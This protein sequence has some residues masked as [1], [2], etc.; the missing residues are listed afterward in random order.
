MEMWA[1]ISDLHMMDGT[2]HAEPSAIQGAVKL[3]RQVRELAFEKGI[4]DF[5]LVLLGDTIDLLRSNRWH[6]YKM[7]PD[8][9]PGRI[10]AA[11]FARKT[12]EKKIEFINPIMNGVVANPDNRPFFE[13]LRE[14]R[15]PRSEGDSVLGLVRFVPGNHDR[16]IGELLGA[17]EP[18]MKAM[19]GEHRVESEPV[20]NKE[21]DLVLC[22]GNSCDPWNRE[23]KNKRLRPCP[24]GDFIVIDVLNEFPKR[25]A[26]ELQLELSDGV[27]RQYQR[28]EDVSPA[29]YTHWIRHNMVKE[30][31][32]NFGRTWRQWKRTLK[33][34]RK[35]KGHWDKV[36]NPKYYLRQEE[37]GAN[38]KY[39]LQV[40]GKKITE[41]HILLRIPL[42][43]YLKTSW[44]SKKITE[45]VTKGNESQ[46]KELAFFG[47]RT[48]SIKS[49]N[50]AD[51]N[52]YRLFVA[53]HTHRVMQQRDLFGPYC[54]GGKQQYINIGS[55]KS[56]LEPIVRDGVTEWAESFDACVAVFMRL[57]YKNPVDCRLLHY[58][59][60][61]PT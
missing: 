51:G 54:S 1:V 13:C 55:W 16:F 20:K 5:D 49:R 33:E 17:F 25:V 9:S 43:I 31:P 3:L 41:I 24:Y 14:L 59:K 46:D 6:E 27:V 12:V 21:L 8:S 48:L 7:N 38:E 26:K 32:V 11:L 37:L 29:L 28:L 47:G 2:L 19:F 22:H 56:S 44:P 50:R 35:P 58:K 23:W 52:K 36:R 61:E 10:P 60:D 45:I 39:Y 15:E 30:N 4:P 34:F 57:N 18:Q 40:L 42:S 53:G